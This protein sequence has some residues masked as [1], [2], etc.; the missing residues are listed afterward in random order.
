MRVNTPGIPG[1]FTHVRE[2]EGAPG[3]QAGEGTVSQS[4]V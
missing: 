2:W 1:T 4:A 3:G